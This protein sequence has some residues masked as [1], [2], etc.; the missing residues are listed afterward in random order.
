V[1]RRSDLICAGS[2]LTPV[3]PRRHRQHGD[4]EGLREMLAGLKAHAARKDRTA[5]RFHRMPQERDL[6]CSEGSCCRLPR[7]FKVSSARRRNPPL[8]LQII[9]CSTTPEEIAIIAQSLR[10]Y[11]PP[12][13]L[14]SFGNY[15]G[16][17]KS[18][19]KKTTR[20]RS[21]LT[22]LTSAPSVSICMRFGAPANDFI[23]DS[24]CDRLWEIAQGRWA[25]V[26]RSLCSFS[27][28]EC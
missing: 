10:P 25:I 3:R 21:S 16:E 14:D 5:P 8:R 24:I 20:R 11:T 19:G 13:L 6:G 12:L 27:R 22:S 2:T 1:R 17:S 15:V 4:P 9:D 18:N 26:P 7:D 28:S 23:F